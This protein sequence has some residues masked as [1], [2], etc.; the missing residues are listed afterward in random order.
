[1]KVVFDGYWWHRGPISNQSVQ[2]AMIATWAEQ[3]PTDKLF[4]VAPPASDLDVR[5]EHHPSVTVV[6]GPSVRHPVF[7]AITVP[8]VARRV[9]AD[10]IVAHNFAAPGRNSIVFIHDVMFMD[11]REWFTRMENVYFRLMLPMARFAKVIMTSSST[12]ARRISRFVKREVVPTGLAVPIDLAEAIPSMPIG[13]PPANDFALLVGRLT[14]RKNVGTAI[15][16]FLK[17]DANMAPHSMVVVGEPSSAADPELSKLL[18]SAP[19]GTFTW[20]PRVTASELSWLYRNA[21]LV[22]APSLDEG[23][24]LPA[25][26][27]LAMGQR[28]LA[29]DTSVFREVVGESGAF[30]DARDV[31]ALAAGF[32]ASVNLDAITEGQRAVLADRYSWSRVVETMRH[33]AEVGPQ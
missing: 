20:M 17:K 11:H 32:S 22:V 21:C 13:A 18:G 19:Q 29:N 26:E 12:E 25:L 15:E 10:A 28:L 14:A 27:A 8:R 31:D 3:F 1:M 16:A 2:R 9:Q 5:R 23:F 4:V 33:H 7:N 24:G 30:V 6:S